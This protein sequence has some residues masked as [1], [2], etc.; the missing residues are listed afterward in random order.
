MKKT[1]TLKIFIVFLYFAISPN[2]VF[3]MDLDALIKEKPI[4]ELDCLKFKD[5]DRRFKKGCEDVNMNIG[6][7]IGITK[8]DLF[9]KIRDNIRTKSDPTVYDLYFNQSFSRQHLIGAAEYIIKGNKYYACDIFAS[10]FENSYGLKFDTTSLSYSACDQFDEFTRRLAS[11][12]EEK[13]KNPN[14]IPDERIAYKLKGWQNKSLSDGIEKEISIALIAFAKDY[15]KFLESIFSEYS[16]KNNKQMLIAKQKEEEQ[17][18]QKVQQENQHQKQLEQ[19]GV[20]YIVNPIEIEIDPFKFKGKVVSCYLRFERRMSETIASFTSG[21]SNKA[22]APDVVD[23]IIVSGIPRDTHFVV[24][25]WGGGLYKLIL[26][27][28]GT[29]TGTNAF[30]AKVSIPHFQYVGVIKK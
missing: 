8:E 30:G 18:R 26:R 6:N 9:D 28:K 20:Q 13:R 21:Y 15:N 2:L 23:Q 24:T 27:G 4:N 1:I 19:Y 16:L 25:V 3:C 7:I 12:Y 29:T 17:K 22:G 10:I 14:A 5:G 11:F